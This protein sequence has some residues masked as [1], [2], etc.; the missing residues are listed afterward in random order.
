MNIFFKLCD[1]I[2]FQLSL[3][4]KTQSYK[5]A[6]YD[7]VLSQPMPYEAAIWPAKVFGGVLIP[8]KREI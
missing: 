5:I 7:G 3:S 8:I 4:H 1:K 6:Y 2:L